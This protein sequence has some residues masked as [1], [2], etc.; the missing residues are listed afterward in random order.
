MTESVT[1]EY[2][3]PSRS[4]LM[5]KPEPTSSVTRHPIPHIRTST[6]FVAR[7][8]GRDC[9]LMPLLTVETRYPLLSR[10]IHL[11]DRTFV[12]DMSKRR[13]YTV[14]D[15]RVDGRGKGV[16]LRLWTGIRDLGHSGGHEGPLDLG[17][18]PGIVIYNQRLIQKL[19]LAIEGILK[20]PKK[21]SALAVESL[22]CV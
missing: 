16:H 7:L 4:K 22:K 12:T 11:S 21:T 3:S 1:S 18:V 19:L 17:I 10:G 13:L 5:S 6:A 2:A 20:D 15:S 9:E 8:S 14:N